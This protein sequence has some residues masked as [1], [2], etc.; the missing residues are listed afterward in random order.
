MR[1]EFLTIN[2]SD[3]EIIVR[4]VERGKQPNWRKGAKS[5]GLLPLRQI[6]S[7]FFVV[8]FAQVCN[9]FRIASYFGTQVA[10]Y[11]AKDKIYWA[12]SKI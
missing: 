5:R 1:I 9:F 2:A 11:R 7:C 4:G 6:E 10:L 3:L 8:E 12:K